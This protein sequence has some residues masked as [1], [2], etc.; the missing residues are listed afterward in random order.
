[1]ATQ[2][3]TQY[4]NGSKGLQA[5]STRVVAW[6]DGDVSLVLDQSP[7][8]LQTYFTPTEAREIANALLGAADIAEQQTATVTA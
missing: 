6:D 2:V 8:N 5:L 1:M 4:V 7:F 3:S